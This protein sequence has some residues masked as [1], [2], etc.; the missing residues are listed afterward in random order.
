MIKKRIAILRGGPSSEYEISLKTGKSVLDELRDDHQT[1]D[2][3]ID[4]QGNWFVQGF[5]KDPRQAL[6]NVDG[7][8]NAMHGEYGED[9]KVQ[10]LLEQIKVP[11][12]G[13]RALAAALSM[14]KDKTKELY[15]KNGIKTPIHKILSRP[16]TDG[17]LDFQAMLIFRN[18]TMPVVLK[19]VDKG[20]S[21]G[22]SIARDFETLKKSMTTLYAVH[23]KILVEEYITG[24]E[25]TVGII[26]NMRGEKYYSL[27]PTEIRKPKQKELFD[28]ELKYPTINSNKTLESAHEIFLAE[29]IC[30][31]SFNR[32]ESQMLQDLAKKAHEILDLRHY[33]RT[34][35]IVNPRRG[36]YALETNALPGLTPDCAFPK[37]LKANGITY[38]EFLD[39][40]IN[41]L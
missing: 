20:S 22:V 2:I 11:Y 38:R 1:T 21:I 25:A 23:E 19:P 10:Q 4:K 16:E 15:K 5:P 7:V 35:F 17:G 24:K 34:D 27:F 8:W 9:G 40:V 13:A 36:I 6:Q 14:N 32:E 12:T 41:S 18:F 39:H 29:S 37:S 31:G 3:V 33:S 28:Y 30:P 26:E